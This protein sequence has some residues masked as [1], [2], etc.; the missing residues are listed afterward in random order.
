MIE[1]NTD[2]GCPESNAT[3]FCLAENITNRWNLPI[4]I[5]WLIGYIN[6]IFPHNPPSFQWLYTTEKQEHVHC[7]N[8]TLFY[9]LKPLF[10]S[11]A[12]IL[13]SP[14]NSATH[15][16]FQTFVNVPTDSFSTVI[17]MTNFWDDICWNIF[18]PCTQKQKN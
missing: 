13:H 8:K 3:H 1:T 7:N 9:L 15:R 11:P 17:L 16:H 18:Q 5:S 14:T 6:I 4:T 10:T 2:N 12:T